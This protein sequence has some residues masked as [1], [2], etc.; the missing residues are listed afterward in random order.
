METEPY[1]KAIYVYNSYADRHFEINFAADENAEKPF[2]HLILTGKNGSGKT[3][4][5]KCINE[6][7]NSFFS[8]TMIESH[9]FNHERNN[10][11]SLPNVLDPKVEIQ[12]TKTP[13]SKKWI[14]VAL[15][16]VRKLNV[17]SAIRDQKIDYQTYK[18]QNAIKVKERKDL[19]I[20]KMSFEAQ[21]DSTSKH[22]INLETQIKDT[23]RQ[24]LSD[25]DVNT[26]IS[27][28][29]QLQ[30]YENQRIQKTNEINNNYRPNLTQLSA[31]IE[32]TS[33][34]PDLPVVNLASEWL[35]FLV[36]R[37]MNQALA[38]A[39]DEFEK[40]ET[41]TK[42]FDELRYNLGE[43]FEQP[44]LKLKFDN[45]KLNF[46][47]QL[48]NQE[49]F[50]L[51]RLPDGFSSFLSIAAE[52]WLAIEASKLEYSIN[53]NPTGI[54]VVDEIENHLHP[55]LQEK[56]LP[57]LTGL[58]PNIQFIVATHS[59]IV[60]ASI[61]NATVFD[62]STKE[63]RTDAAGDSINSLMMSHFGLESPYSAI[64]RKFIAKLEDA[65][66][67]KDEDEFEKIVEENKELITDSLNLEVESLKMDLEND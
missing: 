25:L 57:F 47:I 18:D 6:E 14:Y 46:Y 42:W 21:I 59:P 64:A 53:E 31:K 30:S 13:E 39:G 55:S 28:N 56:I 43:M 36:N 22:I 41:L 61:T 2:R 9:Y 19:L 50:D 5:L 52:I 37:K 62:L 54:V 35:Q 60:I 7:L 58:F 51:N 38:I 66:K 16:S 4:I 49:K 3:T 10:G 33:P 24:L 12:F 45:E 63:I 23:K 26:H 34:L 44:E 65:T 1:L 17:K 40:T 32:N 8:D 29:N 48:P 15:G 20:Q 67:K 11:E 27:L